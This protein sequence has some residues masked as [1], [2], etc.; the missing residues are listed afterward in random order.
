MS[1]RKI[2]KTFPRSPRTMITQTRLRDYLDTSKKINALKAR[3]A[4]LRAQLID[5][6]DRGAVREPGPL[7][8]TIT[9]SARRTLS[10]ARIS[11]LLGED[12]ATRIRDEI[13]PTIQTRVRVTGEDAL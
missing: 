1:S 3:Q 7:R 2:L 5:L 11:E 6:Y 8:V 12:E 9:Q 4:E 10:F 13:T